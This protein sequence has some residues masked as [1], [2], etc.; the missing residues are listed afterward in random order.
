MYITCN[1]SMLRNA[2]ACWYFVNAIL[3][4]SNAALLVFLHVPE[5]SAIYIV[6]KHVMVVLSLDLEPI[7]FS[8][9]GHMLEY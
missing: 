7:R 6:V 1:W 4:A 3:S 9:I 2:P 5:W 8:K